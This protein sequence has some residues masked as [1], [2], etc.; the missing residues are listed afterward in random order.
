MHVHATG[1][2]QFLLRDVPMITNNRCLTVQ[3]D[4]EEIKVVLVLSQSKASS[5]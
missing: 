3:D 4:H 1:I 2:S 5:S